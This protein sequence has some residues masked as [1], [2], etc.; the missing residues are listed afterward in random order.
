MGAEVVVVGGGPVGLL[1]A[2]ELAG[3]GVDT[4]VVEALEGV[5]GQPKA[6]TLHARTVQ[7]LARRGY[8]PVLAGIGSGSGVS[9]GAG[10]GV[11]SGV[12]AG[13]G[14]SP[15]ADVGVDTVAGTGTGEGAGTG[16]S[17]G[18]GTGTGVSPGGGVDAGVGAGT[19]MSTGTDAGVST[20]TG[21][22]AGEVTGAGAGV[23]QGAGVGAVV[24]VDVGVS[25]GAAPGVGGGVF[26]FGGIPG[27]VIGVPVG[28]PGAVWKVAQGDLE[29]VLEERA[30]AV[31]V[32]VW[33]GLRVCGVWQGPA[34]VRVSAQGA[35]GVVRFDAGYVV[36]AD[37]ARSVV[38]EV[39]GF[40]SRTYPATVSA[41]AGDVRLGRG[42]GLRAGWHRTGRGWILARD[43]GAGVT[44]LRTLN[45]SGPH[46]DRHAPL[47]LGE[48]RR[49]VS[50][51]AGRDIA[52][53]TPRW[54]SRFSD[55]SR[56]VSSYRVGR[57]LLAGDAAH[58]HFPIGGQ[59]LSAGLLD[60]LG[61]GWKL[62]FT[63]RGTAGEGLLD[64]YGAERRPAAERVIAHTRAQLALMRPDPGLDPL[65][66]LFGEL[67]A[68]GGA[69][70]GVLASMVSGQD[71]VLPARG[72]GSSPWEG[73][74]VPD[75][76]LST[77]QGRTQV[78]A[79]LGGGRPLLLLFG[80]GAGRYARQARPWAR[81][82]RVVRADPVPGIDCEALL[83]R[84]DGYAG[85][86]AGGG[87]LACA[88]RAYCG[89]GTPPA[90]PPP[91][92]TTPGTAASE[93]TGPEDTA[94]GCATSGDEVS[95]N[96][97]SENAVSEGAVPGVVVSG[98]A[99]SEDIAS[100]CATLG[101]EVSGNA[102]SEGAVPGVVA[103]GD[104]TSE[105]TASGCTEPGGV[106]S[107]DTAPGGT[108]A[109][110]GVSEGAEPTAAV[111]GGTASGGTAP[112]EVVSE[113]T[114]PEG[115][116]PGGTVSGEGVSGEAVSGGA[117][118]GAVGSGDCVR[119]EAVAGGTVSGGVV[120][121]RR[122]VDGVVCGCAGD[123]A[124]GGVS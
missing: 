123:G 22:G 19:G 23:A 88:L 62:A 117:A 60:A 106:V 29:R 110:D 31:G 38:R 109:G 95:G 71:T 86:A 120:V 70:G 25:A 91:G 49:E 14:V 58:V 75:A 102:V 112:G 116:A 8:L 54:L 43:A 20:G 7:C 64:S 17:T 5:S 94:S 3:F 101:D 40:V 45:C 32:R 9:P 27:L 33:R 111:P 65:R 105:G 118:L 39:G 73:R 18:V 121:C 51:I 72:A 55:F 81:L 104:S 76:V 74:F 61:L 21:V 63:V 2:C 34:G 92:G 82:V 28:E 26:H 98:D 113:A 47:G 15:G 12:G 66:E 114:G 83:V 87:A 103:S 57:I 77:A 48:L 119:G 79:L 16:V 85:W 107:G 68:A 36:G 84:P 10:T 56:L 4:V 69:E 90:G 30:R 100:G 78:S 89:P 124:E 6:T 80:E 41:M 96:I 122:A 53:D 67:M 99:T 50:F 37:G 46:P 115:A 1:L 13:S 97:V 42:E 24:G 35:G 52:M 108:A 59:G 44:R 93:N 11:S